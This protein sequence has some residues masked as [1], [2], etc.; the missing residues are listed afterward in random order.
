M[1][2]RSDILAIMFSNRR[3]EGFLRGEM[4]K[5]KLTGQTESSIK[6]LSEGMLFGSTTKGIQQ[7][8]L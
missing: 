5:H 4:N 6:C 1:K 2:G 7:T 8:A 3:T